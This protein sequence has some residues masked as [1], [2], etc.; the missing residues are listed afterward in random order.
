MTG[1]TLGSLP[2]THAQVGRKPPLPPQQQSQTKDIPG[3]SKKQRQVTNGAAEHQS[4]LVW[5]I[6]KQIY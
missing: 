3:N 5:E 6:I 4:Q 1:E 2:R